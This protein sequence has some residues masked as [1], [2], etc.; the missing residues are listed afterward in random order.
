MDRDNLPNALEVYPQ[1]VMYQD[2]S[3]SRYGAPVNLGV[4]GLQLIANPL[5]G[6]G[7]SLKIAQNSVLN[8]LRLP[9]SFL[10]V[11]A[12]ST[13]AVNAIENVVDVE[14]VVP[15]KGIAS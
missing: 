8:Q 9:K 4:K 11:L 15:H 5:S 12:I 2:I 10:A 7:E 13:D 1:V 14:A 3:E 6:F